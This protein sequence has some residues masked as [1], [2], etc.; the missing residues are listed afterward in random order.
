MDI[1]TL[2]TAI[3]I[4]IGV[5]VTTLLILVA[6]MALFLYFVDPGVIPSEED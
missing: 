2:I 5:G 6:L 1:N 3:V 4:F